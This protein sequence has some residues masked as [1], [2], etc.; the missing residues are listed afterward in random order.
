MKSFL[1][2]FGTGLA[3]GMLYAPRSGEDTREQLRS[4]TDEFAR[5]AQEQSQRVKQA[6]G[7]LREQVTRSGSQLRS[8]V[9]NVASKVGLGPLVRLNTASREDLMGLPGIGPALADRII[10]GRPFTSERQIVERGILP[11]NTFDELMRELKA[12]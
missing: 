4:K 5:V 3:L 6:A 2:G 9:Q 12:A 1:A 7:E 11:Q 8:T 10:E